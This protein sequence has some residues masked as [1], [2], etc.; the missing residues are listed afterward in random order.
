MK[1]TDFR[2]RRQITI[3]VGI[4][5]IISLSIMGI[6]IGQFQRLK[7]REDTDV[8]MMEQIE[9]MDYVVAKQY[10]ESSLKLNAALNTAKIVLGSLGQPV[11]DS[12]NPI[13]IQTTD[14]V[15]KSKINIQ[16]P[17]VKVGQDTLYNNKI[18]PDLIATAS[19]VSISIFQKT[20][21]GYVSIASSKRSDG[22]YKIDFLL[23]PSLP[24]VVAAEKN[25]KSSGRTKILD[26]WYLQTSAPIVVD[27]QVVGL[28]TARIPEK[29]IIDNFRELFV[30]KKYF[31]SGVAFLL[32]KEGVFS[33]HPKGEGV[34]V[35]DK[36]V[37]VKITEGAA[38]NSKGKT[39][40]KKDEN[41]TALYYSEVEAADSYVGI[42]VDMKE[43]QKSEGG[44]SRIL[45]ISVIICGILIFF[46]LTVIVIPFE[47]AINDCISFAESIAKGNLMANIK[48]D[49]RDEF[50]KLAK[51]LTRMADKL[52]EIMQGINEGAVELAM[53]SQQ[54][55]DGAQQL[56]EGAS[57]Q[58][59]VAEEVASSMEEMAA[60]IQMNS[61]NA[62]RT[63]DISKNAKESMIKMSEAGGKSIDSINRINEKISV[64][65]DIAF[66]TNILALNAAVEAA[67]AGENGRGFTVVANEVRNLAERSK[68]EAEEITSLSSD[69]AAITNESERL[70]NDLLPEIEQ[71]A[72]LVQQIA[73]ASSEQNANVDQVN[74]A[75]NSLNQVVQ[76]NATA[77]EELASSAEELAVRS[78]NFKKLISFFKF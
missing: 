17:L 65:N 75:I 64:I 58:A 16:I 52:R 26:E 49:R 41:E 18:I 54:I 9:D 15:T 55:S 61:D 63:N 1:I 14:I 24:A 57:T 44:L 3:P 10:S 56:S 11:I 60:N 43:L 2:I 21:Y 33:V 76:Q 71:T 36:D 62:M 69:S 4:L 40:F 32:D 8:R 19:D 74:N 72:Q 13:D 12:N 34:S 46:L 70:I 25:E 28:L 35:K 27:S 31:E 29:D 47:K 66:Q 39:S 45:S 67:R 30:N 5:L 51:S 68:S 77:S 50:G 38:S 73:L 22:T 37:Y 48:L 59:S 53:A 7:I 42:S 23:P 6:V 78:D 20:S